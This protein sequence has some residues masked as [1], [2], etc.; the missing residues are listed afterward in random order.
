MEMESGQSPQLKGFVIITLPPADNPS[1]GKT[2]TA[3]TLSDSPPTPSQPNQSESQLSQS[4]IPIRSPPNRERQFSLRRSLFG[5][6]RLT[7]GLL[8]ISLV[9]LA[10]W[11]S[12]CSNTHFELRDSNDDRERSSF[13]FPLYRKLGTRQ[14]SKGDVQL[15]LGR[16]VRK[17]SV[18]LAA[19]LDDRMGLEKR[20]QDKLASIKSAA[21]L[22]VRGNIFPDGLYYTYMFLGSPAK[23]YYVD[24]DTGSDLTW[25]QCDAPCS[26]CAKGAHP[27][28]NPRKGK[29]IH[30]KDSLCVEVQRNQKTGY[31]ETCHQCDYEIEYAD[32]SSS[33]GVL[34]RD[35]LHLMVTNGSVTKTSVVF[36]CAY[37]QQGFLLNALAAT[38]GILGLSRAKVSLPSQLASQG[39]INNVIGHCLTPDAAGGGYMFLGDGF[40]NYRQMA[41]VPMLN[42]PSTNFYQTEV[43]KMSYGN[44][45]LSLGGQDNG[46]ARLV[47]DSGSSYTYFTKQV[48]SD[49]LVALGDVSSKG[50]VQDP[51][52][53]TLPICWR[54]KFPISSVSDVKQFFKPL[55]LQFG[56]Q[57][58]IISRKLHILPEGYLII[59]NKGN[60]CLG[61]LD[62]SKVHDGSTLI[63][64]DISLRGHLMVYDNVNHKIGWAQ[65]D[66][67]KPHSFNSLPSFGG[68]DLPS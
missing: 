26:S 59:S 9:A 45:K 28:Y 60:V 53:P 5:N 19:Q 32:K 12:A 8:G 1:L 68:M 7:L 38:D 29:I 36:G 18:V 52:D 37:D 25:I 55:T 2:I 58:W 50:L 27:L 11:A 65:S 6:P 17:D 42:S 20:D 62:G 61:I 21:I 10:F 63:L 31:C 67:V 66:C 34:A 56:S 15:K 35:D 24:I 33:M 22:P 40:V 3:F 30:A 23:P 4:Q 14:M 41:W 44:R 54:F 43:I 13:V 39:I 64:G 49:L 16:F 57:W 48:Y 51:S 46:L 47:F